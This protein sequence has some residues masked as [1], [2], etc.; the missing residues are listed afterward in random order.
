MN[1]PAPP[2]AGAISLAVLGDHV[3]Y[4][5]RA[6][7]VWQSTDGGTTWEIL[8]DELAPITSLSLV[9]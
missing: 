5:T 9:A 1:G 7:E 4:G 6:G 2:A 8:V 3:V